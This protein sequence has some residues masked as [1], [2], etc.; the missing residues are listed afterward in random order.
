LELLAANLQF[1]LTE[2]LKAAIIPN[3][4]DNHSHSS[5]GKEKWVLYQILLD[6]SKDMLQEQACALVLG[7]VG[8]GRLKAEL[9]YLYSLNLK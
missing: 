8:M 4:Y 7:W 1:Y 9:L 3:E 2:A 6:L 5:S